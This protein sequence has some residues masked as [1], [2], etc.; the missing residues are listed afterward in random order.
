MSNIMFSIKTLTS[1]LQ[2]NTRR[3]GTSKYM[4]KNIKVYLPVS[5]IEEMNRL[6][7]R[8][9]YSNVKEHELK[10]LRILQEKFY[11]DV[12]EFEKIKT[13]LEKENGRITSTWTSELKQTIKDNE[14]ISDKWIRWLN[15]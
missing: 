1:K 12:K 10:R 11:S 8:Q 14:S 4:L 15:R 13:P 3:F 5:D 2:L 7:H 9:F 6:E